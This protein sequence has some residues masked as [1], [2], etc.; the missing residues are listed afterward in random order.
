MRQASQPERH[1]RAFHATLRPMPHVPG[2]HAAATLLVRARQALD[3]T[4]DDLA[5]ALGVARRTIGR[6]EGLQSTPSVDDLAKLARIAYPKDPAL[7][8]E[9]AA[10]GG[11]TLEG[12]GLAARSSVDPS[13]P[14]APPIPLRPFPPVD[15]V[16]D[17]IVHVAARALDAENPGSD[18]VETVRAV[19]RAAFARARGLGLTVEEIDDALSPPPAPPVTRGG[20]GASSPARSS[21]ASGKV[22]E[23]AAR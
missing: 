12:L 23:R 16:M 2:T 7:A 3:L 21:G 22:G 20:A 6:W 10:E 18:S 4:Q 15:L 14:V 8:A 1:E 19:L 5:T 9:I 11:A 17:S 13:A